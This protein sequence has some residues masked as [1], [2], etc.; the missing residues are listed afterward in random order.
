MEVVWEFCFRN[1]HDFLPNTGIV[2]VNRLGRDADS[3]NASLYKF[4]T[5]QRLQL[6]EFQ[7]TEHHI[8]MNSLRPDKQIRQMIRSKRLREKLGIMIFR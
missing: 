8:K 7:I 2:S 4:H 3:L 1:W 5:A 6:T